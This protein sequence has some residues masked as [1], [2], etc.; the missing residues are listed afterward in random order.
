MHEPAALGGLVLLFSVAVALVLLFHRLRLPPIAG[1]LLAGAVAGPQALG[2]IGDRAEVEQL[3]ELGVIALLFGIGLELP[4]SRVR[5]LWRPLLLGGGL[6]VACTMLAT[7]AIARGFGLTW[8][9]AWLIGGMIAISSTAIV[10]RSLQ[11]TGQVEAP[12]GRATLSILIFQDLSVVPLMMLLP[13]LA[14]EGTGGR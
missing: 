4:V 8:G 13:F 2:L 14:G 3:A 9:Q 11:E 6:Q 1:F 5:R 10:L 7:A 12:H